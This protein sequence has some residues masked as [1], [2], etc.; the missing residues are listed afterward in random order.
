M[1]N[2]VLF[3]VFALCH[4]LTHLAAF[5]PSA[6]PRA[7]SMALNIGGP[8]VH[9]PGAAE[10]E[11]MR[12]A[13]C[14]PAT[15]ACGSWAREQ[16]AESRSPSPGVPIRAIPDLSGD[17]K[18]GPAPICSCRVLFG[19]VGGGESYREP[20][21]RENFAA[22]PDTRAGVEAGCVSTRRESSQQLQTADP[23]I[24]CHQPAHM[25]VKLPIFQRLTRGYPAGWNDLLVLPGES[26]L[27][28]GG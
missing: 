26:G 1:G 25:S 18:G 6:G 20:T 23:P 12:R 7:T 16:G 22:C 21:A 11:M 24:F 5:A 27:D 9:V 14:T 28:A 15:S 8:V 4:L 2:V 10:L 13:H 3:A 17:G 19:W